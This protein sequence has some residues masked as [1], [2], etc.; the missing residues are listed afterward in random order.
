MANLVYIVDFSGVN[1]GYS[2]LWFCI[3]YMVAAYIR[4]YVPIRVKYQKWMFPISVLCALIMCG[5][6]YL[7]YIII[8]H[9]FGPVMLEGF[10]YSYNSI[11]AVPCAITLFQGFCGLQIRS[12]ICK[13]VIGFFAPLTFAAYLI[14]SQLDFIN[15][16]LDFLNA[17]AYNQSFI[18]FPYI[19][20]CTIGVVVACCLVEWVRQLIFRVCGINKLIER[21]SDTIQN[22]VTRW[23]NSET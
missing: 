4:L 16:L 17:N 13:K 12:T 19:A 22:R 20:V 8:P 9:I 7:V 11:I 15:H 23:L 5:E 18:V 2:F 10:F 1:G 14:H 6:K 21:V 3:M